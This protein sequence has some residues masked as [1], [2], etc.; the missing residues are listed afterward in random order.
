MKNQIEVRTMA[1]C[2]DTINESMIM[3]GI[4]GQL[5]WVIYV[6]RLGEKKLYQVEHSWLYGML[7]NKNE[8]IKLIEFCF[9]L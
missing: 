8:E 3:P 2:I 4:N 6:G 7:Y 1:S 9:K 5:H